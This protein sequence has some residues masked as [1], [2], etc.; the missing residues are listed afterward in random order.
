M[1]E[2]VTFNH[3]L[4]PYL[5][6]AP[7]LAIT[8][9]FFFLPA[10]ES[11]LSSFFRETAF[12]GNRLFVGLDNYTSLFKQADY[13]ESIGVTLIFSVAVTFG[14]LVLSLILAVMADRVIKGA[15]VYK[16]FLIIPYAIAPAL[17][18]TLAKFLLSPAIGVVAVHL[19]KWNIDWNPY[20]N[21]A[22]AMML[23]IVTAVWNQI[24][25]NFLF[26]LAGLQSIPDSVVE[27]SA[28]DGAGPMRRF[29]D[30]VFPLLAPTTFFLFII[31]VIY[32]FFETFAIIDVTTQGGPGIATTTMVYGVYKSAFFSY[33]YGTSGAQSVI[34]MAII[35]VLTVLQFKYVEKK[36]H[37]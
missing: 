18:G 21:S 37:Y 30:I 35:I 2:K 3:K 26:F 11:I 34:L 31:N 8:L 22:D 16:T 36:I 28:I 4:L 6:L 5:L 17:I 25:Y 10:G 33:D 15:G 13:Y 19:Q 27:A 24:S 9:V 32:A 14:G 29:R 23:V 20:L 12:G 1:S 7:Q